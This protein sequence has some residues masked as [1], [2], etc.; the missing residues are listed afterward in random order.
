[1]DLWLLES[2]GESFFKYWKFKTRQDGILEMDLTLTKGPNGARRFCSV[3]IL[4]LTG[5]ELE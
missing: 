5:K 2:A 3:T 4:P 1:M